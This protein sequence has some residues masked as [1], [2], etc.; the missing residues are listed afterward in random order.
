M[1]R[2]TDGDSIFLSIKGKLYFEEAMMSGNS[3]LTDDLWVNSI[4]TMV[5]QKPFVQWVYEEVQQ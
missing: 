5:E 3:K 1:N 4:S 2:W